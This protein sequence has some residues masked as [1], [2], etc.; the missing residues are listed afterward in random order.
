VVNYQRIGDVVKVW[1]TV[2]IDATAAL[3]ITELG[4]SLPIN[5]S[6]SAIQDLA[7]TGA[8]DDNTVIKIIGDTSNSR[9]KFRLYPQTATNNEYSFSFTYKY[10]AP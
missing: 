6:V 5:S 2:S 8:C 4:V 1:G 9:A 10:V 7:G 3:A